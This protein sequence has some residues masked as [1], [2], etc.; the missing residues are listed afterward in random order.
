MPDDSPLLPLLPAGVWRLQTLGALR[1][2]NGDVPLAHIPSRAMAALLASL[3]LAPDRDHPR[4]VLAELIWPGVEPATARNRLR[5]ALSTLNKLL[6]VPGQAEPEVIEANR[7]SLRLPSHRLECDAVLFEAH[8]RAGRLD[9]ARACWQGEFMPGHYDEWI[10]E[11]RM[12]LQALYDRIGPTVAAEPADAP[13]PPAVPQPGPWRQLPRHGNT[14]I[15]RETE[16]RTLARSLAEQRLVWITGPAGSGKS[17]LAAEF[18]ARATGFDAIVWVPLLAC[19]A[20]AHVF[21]QL[22]ASL[23]LH[24]APVL[25]LEQVAARLHGLKAL[26]VLDNLEHLLG[27]RRQ[28]PF[29]AE[30]LQRLPQLRVLATS[31]QLPATPLGHRLALPPL[32]AAAAMQLFVS[33]ARQRRTDFALHDGNRAE[34]AA[35]CQRSQGL[36]LAIE[37]LAARVRDQPLAQLRSALDGGQAWPAS[38]AGGRHAHARHASLANAIRWSWALLPVAQQQRLV[39]LSAMCSSFDE[40]DAAG[41]AG[42]PL[43]RC[44]KALV[45]LEALSMLQAQGAEPDEAPRWL[46]LDGL[47]RHAQATLDKPAQAAL[48]ARHRLHVF[49][50]AQALAAHHRHTPEAALPDVVQALETAQRDGAAAGACELLL[51][52]RAHW[53]AR[54]TGERVMGLM[55]SVAAAA[56][57]GP[58]RVHL[59]AMQAQLLVEAGRGDAARQS[60]QEAQAAAKGEVETIALEADLA[61]TQVSWRAERDAVASRPTAQKLYARAQTLGAPALVGRAAMLLG[62]VTWEHSRDNKAARALFEGAQQAFEA[63]GDPQAALTV[64]PGLLVCLLGRRE[65][66]ELSAVGAEQARRLGHVHLELLLLNREAEGAARLRRHTQALAA[67][68]RQ[69]RRA[70]KHGMAYHLVYALWN[71]CYPLARLGQP[72]TAA[73]LMGFSAGWWA[74]DFAPLVP[75]DRRYIGRVQQASGLSEARWQALYAQGGALPV[76]EGIRLG[77]GTVDPGEAVI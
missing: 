57:A 18:G 74:A 63:A 55:Q 8:V 40:H 59:L 22:R 6:T 5:N 35:L 48:R 49:S 60:A 12:R 54:G 45:E 32:G 11:E 36:P 43:A 25:P 1:A 44:R 71:Q 53:V 46:M 7:R 41:L 76:T 14:F 21:E 62:A 72:D 2:H 51:A 52:M 28:V 20:A 31:Q 42:E 73:R 56:P 4:E 65:A 75:A 66:V 10:V 27:T 16:L 64:L 70:R 30:L 38:K 68:Q 58:Q 24:R 77:Q 47:R 26:L 33:R 13:A 17:R 29:L 61:A 34:L 15:G 19:Q 23:G 50:K 67:G 3:A 69:A 39:A 9:Q 37:L